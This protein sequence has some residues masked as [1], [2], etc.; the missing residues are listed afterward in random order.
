M[1]LPQGVHRSN[2]HYKAIIGRAGV[3][4]YLGTFETVKEAEEAYLAAKN[5]DI[6]IKR[7][8]KRVKRGALSPCPH[9]IPF[10][11]PTLSPRGA[12]GRV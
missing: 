3:Q 5:G 9:R 12:R 1:S 8:R 2:Q 6:V 11:F 10:S 4:I 7:Q